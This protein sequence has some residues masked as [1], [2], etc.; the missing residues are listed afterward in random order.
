MGQIILTQLEHEDNIFMIIVYAYT[1]L[2][3][4]GVYVVRRLI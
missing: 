4:G 2:S 3:L 1:S